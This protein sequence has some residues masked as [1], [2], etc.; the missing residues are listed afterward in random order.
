MT[1]NKTLK[2]IR[3]NE[4]E[5]GEALLARNLLQKGVDTRSAQYILA[6]GYGSSGARAALFR[7]SM[8]H[9]WLTDAYGWRYMVQK[10]H[11][12]FIPDLNRAKRQLQ[13]AAENIGI[14]R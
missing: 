13:I 10:G 12:N 3:E 11:D 9:L 5:G 4:L 8:G 7:E 2:F 1:Q 6:F 14:E